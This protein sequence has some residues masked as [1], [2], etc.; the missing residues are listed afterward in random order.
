M[1]YYHHMPFGAELT[2]KG[3]R[4]RLWAPSAQ[5]VTLLLGENAHP[6]EM[7]SQSEG[8]FELETDQATEGT[9][10]RYRIND[11]AI[12]PDPA[13]R[14][15]PQDIHGFSQVV[16]PEKFQWKSEKWKGRPWEEAVIY[17][18]HIGAFTPEGTFKA[19]EAKIPHLVELGITALEIM[20]IADF[21]GRWNWGY[22]G[23]YLFAPDSSYGTPADLKSLVQTAHHHRLMVF[24]DVVYN[25]FGPEGNYLHQYAPDFFTEKYHTPWGAAINYDQENSEW[26]RQFFINNA[27]FWLLEYQLDGLRLDAIHAI[28]D[29]SAHHILKELAETVHCTLE[30]DR[31]IHLIL[32]NDSNE[33]RYLTRNEENQPNWYVAQ[34]NDD[35]HHILHI[36]ATQEK[37]GYYVDYADRPTT[38]LAKCLSQ[39][40]GY[41]GEI[42]HFRKNQPRGESSKDLPPGAFI[43]FLQ[44]H[45]QIGNRAFGDR[46]NT[47]ADDRKIK[48][49]TALILLAPFPP[50]L[51]MGQ[52]WGSKQPFLFFCNFG[53]ELSTNV[54]EGRK[55]EFAAFP[56]FKDPETLERIPDPTNPVAFQN[57]KLNW[58][59][60][61]SSEG[62]GWLS[63]FKRLLALRHE[64]VEPKLNQMTSTNGIYTFLAESGLCITWQFKDCSQLIMFINLGETVIRLPNTLPSQA[65]FSTV[66]HLDEVVKTHILPSWSLICFLHTLSN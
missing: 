38:H 66:E 33:A 18:A 57:S 51:F 45:D 28:Y 29:H 12:V 4:F 26:V 27:L 20:P 22:D 44:N 52:E 10:Y 42:S 16:D 36:L 31:H 47:L 40:F 1:Q 50:M 56:D 41:Q 37:T 43:S 11:G 13:S 64:M 46:I 6:L 49:L 55:R 9:L 2:T 61:E 14:F 15:Q 53:D 39:G 60:S 30:S 3:V 48:V 21:P 54:R 32:E 34:W 65:I 23:V 35:I 58:Q 5:S 25:H 7:P 62:K 8:W 63:L 17:E 59:E 24:L 19:L